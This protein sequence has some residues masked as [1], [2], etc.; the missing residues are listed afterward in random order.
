MIVGDFIRRGIAP[1]KHRNRPLWE[2]NQVCGSVPW[3][4][5]HMTVVHQTIC[6]SFLQP[7]TLFVMKEG[8]FR[9]STIR[10]LTKF[11]WHP[12]GGEIITGGFYIIMPA[13][14]VMRE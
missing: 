2:L 9:C 10:W 4:K 7:G 14:G 13:S 8:L 5:Y 11:S 1:L 3:K 6:M 12:A